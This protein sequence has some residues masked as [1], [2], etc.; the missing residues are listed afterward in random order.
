MNAP[1][2]F[3]IIGKPYAGGILAGRFFIDAIAYALVVAPRAGGDLKPQ[4]WQPRPRTLVKGALSVFD[5]LANTQ[6]MADEGIPLALEIQKLDINGCTDWYLPSR[7]EALLCY[8]ANSE[9]GDEAFERDWYWTST[10]D[11]GAAA[12][13]L[14]QTFHLGTQYCDLK[15]NEFGARAVRRVP[16]Q[17]FAGGEK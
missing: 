2:T 5:G 6:A 9:L 16:I 7:G 1:E 4:V 8:A 15:G 10:Q 11:A 12:W 13:A 3:P 17:P 14:V